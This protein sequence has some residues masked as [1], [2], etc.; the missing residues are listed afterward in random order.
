MKQ[1][2]LSV[3]TLIALAACSAGTPVTITNQS[4]LPLESVVVFGSGFKEPIGRIDPMQ[5]A[6]VRVQP[7]GETGLGISFRAGAR[8]IEAR[9]EGY[10]E[11]GGAYK[12][13]VIVAPDLSTR[14]SGDLKY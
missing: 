5:S 13:N 2:W 4:A 9:P 7:K 8:L 3:F 1:R 6:S 14:V 11:G 12:V 10:F